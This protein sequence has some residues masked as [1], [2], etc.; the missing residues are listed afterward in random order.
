M[1]DA[2]ALIE[3]M[4]DIIDSH[5]YDE[6]TT[7]VTEDVVQI[8]PQASLH[9]A[10]E[11]VQFSKGWEAA[12]PDGR[13]TVTRCL[14]V[15]DEAAVEGYYRG[16]HLGPLQTPQGPIAATGRQF[17][18]KFSAFGRLRDERIAE[19]QVYFDSMSIIAQLGLLPEPTAV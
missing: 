2:R 18:L 5:R 16:T 9:S 11:W 15:G 7:V 1:T 4:F 19:V 3:H 8:N 17:D 10:A 6:F 12:V 13:H 14:Q